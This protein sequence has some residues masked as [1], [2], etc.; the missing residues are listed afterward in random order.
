M[1]AAVGAT[2]GIAR[3]FLSTPAATAQWIVR[4][5][6]KIRDDRLPYHY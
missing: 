2:E 6:N 5:K 4:A 1:H 3:A